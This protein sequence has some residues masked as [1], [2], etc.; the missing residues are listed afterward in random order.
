MKFLVLILGST[1]L[2][3]GGTAIT[4]QQDSRN[5]VIA[6]QR[7]YQE[8]RAASRGTD[9]QPVENPIFGNVAYPL[10][11]AEGSCPFRGGAGGSLVPD[12]DIDGDGVIDISSAYYW[13]SDFESS[14]YP[15]SIISF[16]L[17]TTPPQIISE[18]VLIL[19]PETINYTGLDIINYP[20]DFNI[21]HLGYIDVTADEK[22][23][24]LIEVG[25]QVDE[26][27]WDFSDKYYFYIENISEWTAA[28][29]T[30]INN[31]GSTNVNDLLAVVGNWG[32]CQ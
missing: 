9:C 6:N 31:D 19:N 13:Q 23:D 17:N 29:A 3:A 25:M 16:N 30:D 21:I 15:S 26:S 1:T 28:C 24:A 4:S 27:D 11:V 14:D 10:E 20:F 18:A 8:H 22:P 2:V 7:P 5:N 32:P 12:A